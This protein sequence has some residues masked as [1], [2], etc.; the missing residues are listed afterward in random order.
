[1]AGILEGVKVLGIEQQVA[2]PTCT[3][4]LADQG[5]DVIKV[6][7]PGSG[8][9]AR[10]MAPMLKNDKGE[11][12]SG[13]FARFNRGKKSVTIDMQSPEGQAVLWDLIKDTEIIIE[14]VK[15]GLMDKLGFTYE[16]VK[17]VIPA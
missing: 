5:A 17:E 13:Y 15:P 1:M 4:M 12:Q 6:E 3:M 8:D 7:R 11:A 14:N 16:K 2:G 9:T 10:E